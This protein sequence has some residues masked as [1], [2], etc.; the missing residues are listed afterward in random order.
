MIHSLK[1]RNKKKG[2]NAD[3]LTEIIF[4]L[5]QKMDNSFLFSF[6]YSGNLELVMRKL[7]AEV[8]ANHTEQDDDSMEKLFSILYKDPEK[9]QRYSAALRLAPVTI[10]HK[11]EAGRS[12]FHEAFKLL[13]RG[14][15]IQLFKE[16]NHDQ[17]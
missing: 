17:G 6:N 9:I 11:K 13:I 4:D 1:L 16:N 8:I 3:Q 7:P 10:L 14:I 5:Y 12:G 15:L 2:L